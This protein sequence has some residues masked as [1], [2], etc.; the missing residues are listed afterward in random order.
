[1]GTQIV[2]IH[3]GSKRKAFAV[4]K[5]LI[6]D[7]SEFFDKAFNSGFKESEGFM[8]LLGDDP[9]AFNLLINFIYQDRLPN[10]TSSKPVTD[11]K[12]AAAFGNK[13]YAFFS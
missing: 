10:F 3:V 7:R 8:Y 1:L 5:K 2:T 11:V 4:H 12:E 13:L 6:C 9:T